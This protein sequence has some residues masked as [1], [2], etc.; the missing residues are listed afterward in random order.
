MTWWVRGRIDADD[1]SDRRGKN[2]A[3]EVIEALLAHGPCTLFTLT[4]YIDR[5]PASIY[6]C[7]YRL[8]HRGVVVNDQTTR[9]QTWRVAGWF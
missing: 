6:L 4:R 7:L 9:P 2:L 3:P 5:A 8:M 1:K